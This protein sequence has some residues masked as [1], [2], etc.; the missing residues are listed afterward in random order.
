VTEPNPP[1]SAKRPRPEEHDPGSSLSKLFKG[2]FK[3][4]FSG[5]GALNAAGRADAQG[6]FNSRAYYVT[7]SSLPLVSTND[8]SH[9][10]SDI[11]IDR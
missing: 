4:R 11:L 1:P 3:R 6:T 2:K 8:R 10:H 9:E 7:T 5:S